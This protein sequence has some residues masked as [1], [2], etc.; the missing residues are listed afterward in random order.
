MSI[1]IF[2]MT[3]S[4]ILKPITFNNNFIQV[5]QYLPIEDKLNIIESVVNLSFTEKQDNSNIKYYNTAIRI[6]A[7]DYFLAK[8]YTDLE[9]P[10]LDEVDIFTVYDILAKI[11][12]DVS[13]EELKRYKKEEILPEYNLI[14]NIKNIIP[15][16][17]LE[18]LNFHIN[19]RIK[20]EFR[21]MNEEKT[22][23][24]IISKFLGNINESIP[25]FVE[26]M[27]NLDGE[28]FDTLKEILGMK[29]KIEGK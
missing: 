27:N 22:F 10:D 2:E 23:L 18:F 24:N 16:D 3:S 15:K 9:I 20:E 7:F 8:F 4:L 6:V 14:N 29:N 13:K 1:N 11:V 26:T 28:K 17:E 21:C 25:E 19:K 5:K 12:F